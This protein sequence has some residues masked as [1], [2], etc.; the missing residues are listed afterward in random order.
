VELNITVLLVM[1]G[2]RFKEVAEMSG[3]EGCFDG[4]GDDGDEEAG[5]P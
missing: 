2:Y 1:V 5:K 4:G 3:N